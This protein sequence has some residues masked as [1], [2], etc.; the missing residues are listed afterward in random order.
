MKKILIGT[1]GYVYDS[2]RGILYPQGL[3]KAHW[4]TRYAGIFATVELNATFYR[5]PT[6]ASVERWREGVP[7]D[8]VFACK[9][10]RFLTHMKKLQDTGQGIDRYFERV[11]GLGEK[12]GPILW[13]L[14]P[15]MAR[16]DLPRL[17]AFLQRLPEDLTHVFEFRS[18]EWYTKQTADL[19][20]AFGAA[21]CEHDLVDRRPPRVT[22]G[23]RYLRFHGATAKYGGRYGKRALQPHA[24]SLLRSRYRAFVYFNNDPEGH[25]VLD[26]LDLAELVGSLAPGEARRLLAQGRQRSRAYDRPPPTRDQRWVGG[27]E[28]PRGDEP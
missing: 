6:E 19:L 24:R 26:A 11:R 5:L 28:T 25:A 8:F 13:Q 20:D 16:Q 22:G 27:A 12:L 10:S 1:S 2:W 21:F 15:Q 4:L 18:V 3:G 17:E 7:E 9:G 14:P 23:L